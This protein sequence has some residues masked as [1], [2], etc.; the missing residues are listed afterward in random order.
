MFGCKVF[1]VA[2]VA[3]YSQVHDLCLKQDT[4]QVTDACGLCCALHKQKYF[5]YFN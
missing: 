1:Y 3:L 2:G 5:A 4:V